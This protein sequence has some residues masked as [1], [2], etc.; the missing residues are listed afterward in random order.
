MNKYFRPLPIRILLFST[1]QQNSEN[2]K[3]RYI[4]LYI[5]RPLESNKTVATPEYYKL[6][7]C[8]LTQFPEVKSKKICIKLSVNYMILIYCDLKDGQ[9]VIF[10][11]SIGNTVV[12][13][14]MLSSVI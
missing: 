5:T 9:K 13:G 11:I 7:N 1:I 8:L 4:C 2:L 10:S 3:T 14:G 6:S 12:N